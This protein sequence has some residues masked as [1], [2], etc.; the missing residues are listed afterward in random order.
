MIR[1]KNGH[2]LTFA[3][4]SGALAFDGRGWWW[5]QPLRWLGL[6]DPTAFTVVAKTVTYRPKPGN[7][8]MWHPWTCVRPVGKGLPGLVNAVG[9]TNPGI[10]RW[11]SRD[12]PAA[13]RQGYKIAASVKPETCDEAAAMADMLRPLDLAYVEANL[14]CPNVANDQNSAGNVLANLQGCGHPVVLKLAQNQCTPAFVTGVDE[15]VDAYHAINTIPWGDL[16]QDPS[17]IEKYRHKQ[18][19]GVSGAYI[20]E[21]AV[22]AVK[23]IRQTTDKPV[24]GGGGIFTVEDALRFEWAGAK[25]F[26]LGTC[27][28]YYPWRPNR[29]VR[30]YQSMTKPHAPTLAPRGITLRS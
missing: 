26:S 5:E 10:S 1:F 2:E 30:A 18:K 4:A 6:L 28:T 25:A 7:L 27:F 13:K 29:I 21:Q 12:Y 24:I 8:S 11:V 23:V 14:S 20:I 17:P 9:L 16:Y 15:H 19:G 22:A 3:C